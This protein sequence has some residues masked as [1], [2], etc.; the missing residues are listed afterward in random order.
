V[1]NPALSEMLTP[2]KLAK[3]WGVAADKVLQLIHSGQLIGVN[4]A[5]DPR[6]RPRFRIHVAEIE[7]FEELRSSKPPIPKQR[8]RRAAAT[9]G[10]EYF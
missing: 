9:P 2:P 10:K 3:R 8:R 7:R 1:V 5:V 4:L 6:G